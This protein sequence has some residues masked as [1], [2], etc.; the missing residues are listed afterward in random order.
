MKSN[1]S[2]HERPFI[3]L[4]E[5]T[6]ACALA[7]AHCRAKAIPR[8]DPG[9]LTT[10]EAEQLL[11][12]ITGFGPPLP[13]V[14]FTGGDP[15]RHPDLYR[16]VQSASKRRLRVAL[17]PSGTAGVTEEK[18]LRLKEAG[19]DRLAVS[20]DG[21][22]PEIHD[23]FRGVYGSYAWTLRII[24]RAQALGLSLQVNTT[25]TR[26]NLHDMSA[27][28]DLVAGFG[29]VL[30]AVFFLVPTG[31]GRQ[32]DQITAWECEGVLNDLYERS[33]KASFGIKTT[34]APQY[35]RVT[36]ERQRGVRRDG[37]AKIDGLVSPVAPPPTVDRIPRAEGSINA[38]KGVVFVSHV[39]EV[40]PSGFLPLAAGNVRETSLVR[41]YREHPIFRE[42]RDPDLLTG[43]CGVCQYRDVCG[44]SRARAHALREDYLAEDSLC[45]YDPP[46]I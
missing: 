4:W 13:V 43:R 17:T 35:R 18:L 8:R 33:L 32:R 11:E 5:L 25:I 21:S 42:L 30:W 16:L 10:E 36:L 27:I 34:E 41:L 29:I 19:L 7:C 24:E 37:R 1:G 23:A 44:G 22:T 14:V 46:G 12:E 9:E 20:L 40:Y 45:F 3:V 15:L 39:G 31:R 2:Y 26:H 6:R 38:G 28:G